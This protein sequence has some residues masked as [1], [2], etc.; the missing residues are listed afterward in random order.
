MA[1]RSRLLA[2]TLAFAASVANAGA[3]DVRNQ[4]AARLKAQLPDFAQQD[5]AAGG[6]AFDPD[7]RAK[8]DEN[9]NAGAESVAAGRK[10]WTARF[11]DG[12]SL[13]GCFP[14]GGRR[15]AALYPQYDTRL[16]R[17]VTLETAVNQC[18]KTHGETLY[19]PGDA[20][21]TGVVLAYV[22]SLSDGQKVNVRVPQAA[23]ERFEAGRK[24]YFTRMG[25]RN[26]ACASCH[27]QGAGKRFADAALSP[28][29]GQ[30]AHWP[31]IRE[32][33]PVTIQAR[34]REC[35]ELMG[36]A[37]FAFGSEEL[38]HLEYFLGYLSNGIALKANPWRPK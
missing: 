36:A 3:E 28:P 2:A 30:A 38:N 17:I 9:A 6:A 23:E 32:G 8:I 7:L 14:N 10:L 22:R 33:A 18:L 34:M 21:T 11:K 1:C 20:K 29:I 12:R 4:V 13:S 19:D 16:K 24:L 37:P 25:Q 35:L 15:V 31:V 27:L 5:F 26:F